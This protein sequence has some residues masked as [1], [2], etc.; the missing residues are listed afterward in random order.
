MIILNFMLLKNHLC[1]GR[2]VL[3]GI[4]DINHRAARWRQGNT[5]FKRHIRS[6]EEHVP[7][8]LT[9]FKISPDE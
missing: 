8:I 3:N 7:E 6:T 5:D 9:L 2:K 1:S 4:R